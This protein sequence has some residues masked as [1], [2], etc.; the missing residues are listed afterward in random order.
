MSTRPFAFSRDLRLIAKGSTLS[1]AESGL[2]IYQ[3]PLEGR[4]IKTSVI[5]LV[6]KHLDAGD[7]LPLVAYYLGD[8]VVRSDRLIIS[9]SSKRMHLFEGRGMSAST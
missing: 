2:T 1:V 9:V 8:G 7:P 6:L 5:R 3:I 4:D